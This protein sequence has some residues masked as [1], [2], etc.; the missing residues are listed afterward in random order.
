MHLEKRKTFLVNF[1]YLAVW[2]LIAVAALRYAMPMLAP[3]VIGFIVAYLLQKPIRFLQNKLHLPSKLCAILTVLLFYGTVGLIL[4][5]LSI[6]AFS[7]LTSL[8]RNLPTLY[9]VHVLPLFTDALTSI[10]GILSDLDPALMAA[11]EQVVSQLLSSI[12]QML[13]NASVMAMGMA[14]AVASAL[15]G[16]FI[17]LVLMI[18]SSFFIAIDYDKLTGFC[19]RQLN[20]NTKDVFFQI[21]EYVVGTL[22]VCIRSYL[23]IMSITF[24]EL[25]IG[26]SLVKIDHAILIAFCVSIFDILPVLGTGGIMLPWAALTALRGDFS[27]ALALLIIYL[28]IT[29]IRNIIE[30]KIVGGQLGLH[31]V[32]T[33][34]SMFAGVQLFGGIGLFGFPI[35]LSLLRYLNDHGVLKIFK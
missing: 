9:E 8:I 19:L 6:R 23:L 31:P 21:K 35:A 12:A 17:K 32:V 34:A 4:S 26:L 15:P 33:L 7:G 1:A 10:E 29:V 30:P 27:L 5:L 25:S 18:I 20:N 22:F 28:V 13:S 24:V 11:L 3:F 14:S 2:A 16:L